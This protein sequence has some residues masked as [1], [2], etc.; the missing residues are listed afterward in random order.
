MPSK[1][2]TVLPKLPE[3]PIQDQKW[4]NKIDYFKETIISSGST[5]P[6]ELAKAYANARANKA[7][8][9]AELSDIHLALEA[10]SQMLVDSSNSDDPEWGAYGASP[11]TLR[12]V[13]GDKFE[14]RRE[15]YASIEDKDANR[16]WAIKNGLERMLSLHPSTINSLTKELLLKGEPEPDGVKT[17]V[18]TKIVFTPFK[19]AKENG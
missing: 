12:T 16:L 7:R 8:I 4:Q 3:M 6:V 2:D 14:V 15:P 18:K 19:P 13:N 5:T 1:Y 10:Y 17:F 9:E 11:N